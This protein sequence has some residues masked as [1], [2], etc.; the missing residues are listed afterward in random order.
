MEGNSG[1]LRGLQLELDVQRFLVNLREL[2]PLLED[3]F[4]NVVRHVLRHVL[5]HGKDVPDR[6]VLGILLHSRVGLFGNSRLGIERTVLLVQLRRQVRDINELDLGIRGSREVRH[7]RGWETADPEEGVNLSI[8]DGVYAFGDTQAFLGDILVRIDID[9][10]QHAEGKQLGR[11]A[12]RSRRNPFAL[13]VFDLL[14]AGALNGYDVHMVRVD[15]R[16]S[17]EWQLA[18]K[19]ALAV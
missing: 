4:R 5:V 15:D 12:R 9:S 14:D 17:L 10:L 1:P 18:R 6:D 16:N 8:L 2:V 11:A 3:N 7:R 19:F 13:E